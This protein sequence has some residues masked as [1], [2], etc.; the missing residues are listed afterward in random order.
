MINLKQEILN[1]R[2]SL[3]AAKVPVINTEIIDGE[4]HQETDYIDQILTLGLM[5]EKACLKDDG[6]KT[7]SEVVERYDLY[8]KI[9]D[10]DEADL[11][12]EDIDKLKELL[13]NTFDVYYAGIALTLLK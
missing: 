8:M 1:K 6:S 7:V 2:G 9:K 11:S 4:V 3:T 12:N 10:K 13:C 5:L